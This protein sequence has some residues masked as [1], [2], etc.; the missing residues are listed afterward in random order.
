M[1]PCTI[2][3]LVYADWEKGGVCLTVCICV[4]HDLESRHLQ[5]AEFVPIIP[6]QDCS[7]KKT[8]PAILWSGRQGPKGLGR[9]HKQTPRTGL[10]H[11]SFKEE[12]AGKRYSECEGKVP[13]SDTRSVR[14]EFKT[15]NESCRYAKNQICWK[16]AFSDVLR[17]SW[18]VDIT[19]KSTC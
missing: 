11:P 6:P 13:E 3:L 8:V 5:R 4:F 19:L 18:A 9:S 10:R 1:T 12:G 7:W 17:W 15:K 14:A 2:F 16:C